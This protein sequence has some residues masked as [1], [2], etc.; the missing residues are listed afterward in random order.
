MYS[1]TASELT[2]AGVDVTTIKPRTLR[3][4]NRGGQIPIFVR[5]E[6]DDRFDPTD[7]IVFYGERQHGETSY[8][9]P[10]TD[11]NIY[12][13]SWNAGPGSRMGTKTVLASTS[14]TQDHT[15]FL[16]RA[17]IEKDLTFRRFR[18]INLAENQIYE[19]FSQGLQTRSFRLSELP[20]LPDDSWFWA[21]LT[22]PASK[23]FNFDLA[24][25]AD[26]ARPATV[27]VNLHGRSNTG[28][29]CDIWLN[30]KI[31][32]RRSTMDR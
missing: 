4:T 20:P 16:T 1:I 15:L 7:E 8:I 13:L 2:A 27:S 18:D 19:E 10:F 9:N 5:G 29:D 25:L 21:Q 6:N 24:G 3:L 30:D 26:T 28:H 14:N 31:R 12:W 23:A 22:A 17:H 32:T 11:E